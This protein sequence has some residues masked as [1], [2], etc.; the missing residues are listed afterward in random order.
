MPIPVRL[1]AAAALWT[2]AILPARADCAGGMDALAQRIEGVQDEQTRTLLR[3]D[4]R[5]AHKEA[6]EGD[7]VECQEALDHAQGLLKA[8]N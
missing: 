5:R 4:L 1:L 3:Y 7:E 8:Q 6:G 2:A